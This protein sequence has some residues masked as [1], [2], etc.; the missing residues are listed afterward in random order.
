GELTLCWVPSLRI[1]VTGDSDVT[2]DLSDDRPVDVQ[3]AQLGLT[4]KAFVTNVR[5]GQRNEVRVLLMDA[6]SAPATSLEQFR[7]YLVNFPF[8]LGEAV[9]TGEV[10]L[11][12]FSRD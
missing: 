11:I 4:A 7:F 10:P 6:E 3:F 12:G 2:F 9:R 5:I 8:V 1:L